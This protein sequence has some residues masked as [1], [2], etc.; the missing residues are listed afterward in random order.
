MYL[1]CFAWPPTLR[2][3]KYQKAIEYIQFRWPL[4]SANEMCDILFDRQPTTKGQPW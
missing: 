4:S 3:N 1:S 2:F